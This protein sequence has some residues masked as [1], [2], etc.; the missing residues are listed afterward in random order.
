[1]GIRLTLQWRGIDMR[2]KF[3]GGYGPWGRISGGILSLTI[4]CLDIQ[5]ITEPAVYP[6]KIYL[7]GGSV[8]RPN[9]DH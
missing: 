3:E 9:N 2:V 8:H 7:R 1:M 5:P 4:H 6:D